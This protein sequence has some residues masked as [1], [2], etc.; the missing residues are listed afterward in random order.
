MKNPLLAI[1]LILAIPIAT[2][3]NDCYADFSIRWSN[4]YDYYGG[5]LNSELC[6][7]VNGCVPQTVAAFERTRD[8][9]VLQFEDCIDGE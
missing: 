2:Y 1:L 4:A 8:I 3:S 5:I 7:E 6:S 9:I